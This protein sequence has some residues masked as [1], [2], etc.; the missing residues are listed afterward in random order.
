MVEL[1]IVIPTLN[2]EKYLPKLLDSLKGQTYD[3]YEIIVA[4]S[5]SEDNTVTIAK[6]YG[7]K[8]LNIGRMGPG[9]GR[10]EGAKKAHGKYL[11]FLD[12]DVVLPKK[13][14]LWNFIGEV[15]Y[16]NLKLAN[17]FHFLY[18][19]NVLDIP[20]NITIN[21]YFKAY[22]FISPI[23][24]GFFI[25]VE[26]GVFDAVGGFDEAI[27]VGEDV[28]F[29]RRAHKHAD[30]KMLNTYIYFS[31]R[32]FEREGRMKMYATY[33]YVYF[34][35]LLPEFLAKIE[36]DYKF[37]QYNEVNEDKKYDFLMDKINSF[38]EVHKKRMSN[39]YSKKTIPVKEMKKKIASFLKQIQHK[40]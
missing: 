8:V 32:R 13:D 24:P 3:D 11:L 37:G 9:N 26:K 18:P 23:V 31:N 27:R 6:S 28:D 2:E 36:V 21:L 38:F 10:N 17:C 5:A 19:F 20:A 16:E 35:E 25:F 22:S 7:A 14:F 34:R 39:L 4:D 29:V 33:I 12:A 30:F 1:S 15:K 40:G